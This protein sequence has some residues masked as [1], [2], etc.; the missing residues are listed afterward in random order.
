MSLHVVPAPL[1][2]PNW[3]NATENEKSVE[4]TEILGTLYRVLRG[5]EKDAMRFLESEI[6]KRLKETTTGYSP[7]DFFVAVRYMLRRVCY[8]TI[9]RI[10][11]QVGTRP[12]KTVFDFR[13]REN[14]KVH[15]PETVQLLLKLCNVGTRRVGG[16]LREVENQLKS[17]RGKAKPQS[18]LIDTQTVPAA[19][20]REIF[21]WCLSNDHD[22]KDQIH[23]FAK[24]GDVSAL[25]ASVCESQS[26]SHRLY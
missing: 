2:L 19:P 11:R 21:L 16:L 23:T 18:I 5:L 25:R 26:I 17:N 6:W 7:S 1:S 9:L 10:E 4:A 8:P 3:A 14:Q 15:R 12:L 13:T 24:E 20:A 22:I